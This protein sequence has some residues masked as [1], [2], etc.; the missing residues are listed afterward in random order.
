VRAPAVCASPK[1][2][3][4]IADRH[5]APRPPPTLGCESRRRLVRI[6]P[7]IYGL[8]HC[9]THTSCVCN[10][11]ISCV[12][13]VVGKIPLPNAAGLAML[14]REGRICS[15][16][17]GVHAPLSLE[18]SLGTFKGVKARLYR[19]AYESLLV[20]PLASGDAKIKSFVK[21]E[22]FSP[23][24][25]VNPDPRMIQA[26]NPRYNLHLAR[27]LRPIEHL[28]YG[29]SI[30]G[31][32][33]VAKCLNP[34]QRA[35]L[36][37]QKWACFQDPVCFSLDCSRWDK[38]V[39]SEVLKIE[40]DFYRSCYPGDAELDSLLNWQMRNH[41]VTSNGVK[42]TV[43]GGRMSGDMN[44]ALGNCFLMLIMVKAAMR[45]L[46][47][48]H[49][50]IVDDGDDCLVL[51]ERSEFQ[52]LNAR[53]PEVFLGFGQELKIENVADD[54]RDV[55]FCQARYTYNGEHYVFA[56]NWRKVLSQSCCG[57]KHW[58]DPFMVRPMFGL[59]GDCEIAQHRGI[60][61]LQKFGERLRELSGGLRARWEHLDSSYQYRVGAFFRD[62][63]L[64]SIAA[65]T[66]T[67]EA[68]A[69]F[70]RV[71]DVS[72]VEQL[73]IE[74]QLNNWTPTVDLVDVPQEIHPL[75]WTFQ[76]APH[77]PIPTVL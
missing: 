63:N 8:W 2:L 34:K 44:T 13:R 28:I 65:T 49:Y 38:H 31:I 35:E 39:S 56:R 6:V 64:E 19:R 50:Q 24:D 7:P 1:D 5:G 43:Q 12:N 70:A 74:S 3:E 4:T 23:D 52:K 51:V 15:L 36:L 60:P 58:N 72:I 76:T 47:V 26:R 77:I 37:A 71:W 30:G 20:E 57:T 18:E 61:I 29:W 33:C 59:I 62:V 40:H 9:F 16:K 27:Y 73:A 14:R 42:Y 17:A 68:R 46:G 67:M 69:E 22:K 11:L 45:H 48:K 75:D 55:V 32:R 10:D 25:K 66:I 53:L 21:A 41:C 54:I